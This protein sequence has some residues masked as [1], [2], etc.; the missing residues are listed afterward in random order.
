MSEQPPELRRR[1]TKEHPAPALFRDS[2]SDNDVEDPADFNSPTTKGRKGKGKEAPR[3]MQRS[4][5]N[6][7]RHENFRKAVADQVPASEDQDEHSVVVQPRASA[8]SGSSASVPKI[9][10]NGRYEEEVIIISSDTSDQEDNES[11]FS[12]GDD[13]NTDA[14]TPPH[15]KP[16]DQSHV[17]P[18]PCDKNPSKRSRN[19]S[20][21]KE[22][23]KPDLIASSMR[24]IH[25]RRAAPLATPR[26]R[27][28]QFFTPGNDVPV[29][30][31]LNVMLYSG[32]P[33]ISVAVRLGCSRIRAV[34]QVRDQL[35]ER[36]VGDDW[37][38]LEGLELLESPGSGL[39]DAKWAELM[40]NGGSKDVG[41]VWKL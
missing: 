33:M 36:G 27:S 9:K 1:Q 35:R 24:R 31:W 6:R 28:A 13:L 3:H 41:L 29:V 15:V 10:K 18:S 2:D 4:V 38:E 40:A 11:I 20:V 23:P 37:P 16:K 8:A 17:P 32:H 14:D 22:T 21:P 7:P 12:G 26:T 30:L 5:A 19:H 34:K 39:S 25:P